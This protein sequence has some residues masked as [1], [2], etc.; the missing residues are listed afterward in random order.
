MVGGSWALWCSRLPG[1]GWKRDGSPFRHHVPLRAGAGRCHRA[2]LGPCLPLIYSGSPSP[3]TAPGEAGEPLRPPVRLP[4]C[5][6]LSLTDADV[7]P[8]G[9]GRQ[10]VGP[11]SI[12][13]RPGSGAAGGAGTCHSH[14]LL[15]Q[16]LQVRLQGVVG[17]RAGLQVSL[18]L[19][20]LLLGKVSVQSW[21]DFSKWPRGLLVPLRRKQ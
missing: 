4:V 18:D 11:A 12:L 13:P 9:S 6:P 15:L 14:G 16:V 21:Q 19:C 5:L 20:Q 2:L 1:R 10:R 7:G 3:S 8:P 17:G